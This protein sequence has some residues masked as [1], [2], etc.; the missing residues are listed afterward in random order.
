[1]SKSKP[2]TYSYPKEV[3]REYH[4]LMNSR[5]SFLKQSNLTNAERSNLTILYERLI[6]AWARNHI[7]LLNMQLSSKYDG[8]RR[9]QHELA[10]NCEAFRNEL[11]KQLKA[12]IEQKR[13]ILIERRSNLAKA[14]EHLQ[15]N[16]RVWKEDIEQKQASLLQ[17]KEAS[18][19]AAKQRLNELNNTLA[20]WG[21][22]QAQL[23]NERTRL[24][25]KKKAWQ[26]TIAEKKKVLSEIQADYDKILREWSK[27]S[28]AYQTATQHLMTSLEANSLH[29]QLL[30]DKKL[31]EGK[32]ECELSLSA[33]EENRLQQL[34]TAIVN[35]L[36]E[37]HS[38]LK[39]FLK[40]GDF[41]SLSMKKYV[42][43]SDSEKLKQYLT[44][45]LTKIGVDYE[46]FIQRA[47]T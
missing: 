34:R 40:D 30:L 31:S 15:E 38:E 7:E 21:Q 41:S 47:N 11:D 45:S 20:N 35:E 10:E 43:S 42:T 23:A 4:L 44:R 27:H 39:Q 18:D 13:E 29:E 2:T 32:Q 12:N 46:A 28:Q 17:H 6:S 5:E 1:M 36:P 8:L 24:S 16:L 19:Q 9:M 26:N 37:V 3:E 14:N 33:Q 25:A 22:V